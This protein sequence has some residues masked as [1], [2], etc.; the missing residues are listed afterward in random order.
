[1]GGG[2]PTQKMNRESE[3]N[4]RFL[5]Q[6]WEQGKHVFSRVTMQVTSRGWRPWVAMAHMSCVALTVTELAVQ[7]V[8]PKAHHC[9]THLFLTNRSGGHHLRVSRF[10]C[11]VLRSSV[12][13]FHMFKWSADVSRSMKACRPQIPAGPRLRTSSLLPSLW[14]LPSPKQTLA[15]SNPHHRGFHTCV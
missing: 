12:K 10:R 9:R 11:R 4:E 5:E 14:A 13:T 8:S 2:N 7:G 6:G 15:F 1:M 3:N